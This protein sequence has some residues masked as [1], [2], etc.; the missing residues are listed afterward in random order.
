MKQLAGNEHK[1]LFT[2]N[3]T[4]VGTT[5]ELRRCTLRYTAQRAVFYHQNAIKAI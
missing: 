1:K 5:R 3:G 4:C 2:V